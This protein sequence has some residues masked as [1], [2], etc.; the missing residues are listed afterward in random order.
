MMD[1]LSYFSLQPMSTSG[2]TNA[3]VSAIHQLD[4]AYSTTLDTNRKEYPYNGRS[5]FPLSL[6]ESGFTICPKLYKRKKMRH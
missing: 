3:V 6:F 4:D 2:T 5:G 1:P